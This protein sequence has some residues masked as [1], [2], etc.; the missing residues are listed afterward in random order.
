LGQ[1]EQK[2]VTQLLIEKEALFFLTHTNNLS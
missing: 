2:Q 1:R